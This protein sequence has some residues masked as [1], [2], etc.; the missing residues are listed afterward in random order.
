MEPCS[1]VKDRIAQSM[2]EEAEKAGLIEAGM[3]YI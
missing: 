2:I 1:S 3:L